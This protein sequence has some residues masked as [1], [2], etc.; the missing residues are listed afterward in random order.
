[1][2]TFAEHASR[3]QE[4]DLVDLWLVFRRHQL[5][6]W[7]AFLA[8]VAAGIVVVG[9]STPKYT[10]SLAIQVGG[11]QKS[12]GFVPVASPVAL[13]AVL[14]DSLIPETV[15]K[16]Q[17]GHPLTNVMRV[18]VSTGIPGGNNAIVLQVQGTAAQGNT[19]LA[20]LSQI[21]TGFAN[22]ENP[23][24]QLQTERQQALLTGEIHDL[25]VQLSVLQKNRA[26][27]ISHSDN[28]AKALT[29]LLI[30]SQITELQNQIFNLNQELQV[31][32]PANVKL[33]A[34]MSAPA[35]TLHPVGMSA[36][37]KIAIFVLL[38]LMAGLFAVLAVHLRLVARERLRVR[39]AEA[40]H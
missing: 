21:E 10:Y 14:D 5:A 37:G 39:S 30:N 13:Q 19:L 34:A 24:L 16:F 1:M 15:R 31:D 17:A 12:T 6:F 9:V 26:A 28:N 7:A 18:T 4:I 2:S 35:R 20:L 25:R 36:T 8:V 27:V 33:T 40:A 29:L 22:A 32:L 11:V 3:N 38:G 23:V